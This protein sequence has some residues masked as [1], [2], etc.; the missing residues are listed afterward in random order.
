MGFRMDQRQH[1]R[2][3]SSGYSP[4]VE[5]CAERGGPG[6]G[7]AQDSDEPRPRTTSFAV[8]VSFDL[9]PNLGSRP[10]GSNSLP[11]QHRN[12]RNFP[13]R[14]NSLGFHLPGPKKLEPARVRQLHNIRIENPAAER[15]FDGYPMVSPT[16]QPL[17]RVGGSNM[18]WRCYLRCPWEIIY[19]GVLYLDHMLNRPTH[20]TTLTIFGPFADLPVH[21]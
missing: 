6:E 15:H 14:C 21:T 13:R 12:S 4:T 10:R 18:A 20:R 9:I 2:I 1:S 8:T 16:L 5:T 11:Q 19:D 17:Q 7:S 3:C